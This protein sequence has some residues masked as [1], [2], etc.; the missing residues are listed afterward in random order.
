MKIQYID[1]C[2]DCKHHQFDPDYI[3]DFQFHGMNCCM[4]WYWQKREK[5]PRIIP[6]LDMIPEWC[7]L[8]DFKDTLKSM[9][10]DKNE[11]S[12]D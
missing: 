7:P 2:E 10:K 6:R 4:Y 1:K 8:D 5:L 11:K 9:F 3:H 12:K